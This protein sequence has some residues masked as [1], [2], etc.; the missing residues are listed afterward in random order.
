[1]FWISFVLVRAFIFIGVVVFGRV[2]L[3][4]ISIFLLGGR[5]RLGGLLRIGIVG[6]LRAG[7]GRVGR[8]GVGAGMEVG[9]S[10]CLRRFRLFIIF[11]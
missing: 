4:S 2:G 8:I 11:C 1:M 9:A 6:S 3:F 10:L 5:V 7:F